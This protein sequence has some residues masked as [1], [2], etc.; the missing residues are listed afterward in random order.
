M[1]KTKVMD[2]LTMIY[3]KGTLLL[4]EAERLS[5]PGFVNLNSGWSC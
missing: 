2:Y 1:F 3:N 5:C 4:A